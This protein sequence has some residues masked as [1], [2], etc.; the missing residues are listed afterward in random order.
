[1]GCG[2][3]ESRQM[4]INVGVFRKHPPEMSKMAK[5]TMPSQILSILSDE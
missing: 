5:Y 1:M 4:N 2:P 3:D